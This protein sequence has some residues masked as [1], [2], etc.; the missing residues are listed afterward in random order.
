MKK[1]SQRLPSRTEAIRVLIR[2]G[3]GHQAKASAVHPKRR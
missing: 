2:Q 3:L 1:N